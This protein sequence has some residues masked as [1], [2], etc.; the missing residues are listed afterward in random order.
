[1]IRA[2]LDANQF[3]SA[4]I[5]PD[6]NPAKVLN[7]LKDNLFQLVISASIVEEIKRILLYP[8]LR[9]IHGL[10]AEEIESNIFMHE[11]YLNSLHFS[12]ACL[13]RDDTHR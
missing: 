12:G 5:K 10:E 8:K 7:C 1:M 11:R 2:V 13:A 9:K 3:A 4:L 6:S